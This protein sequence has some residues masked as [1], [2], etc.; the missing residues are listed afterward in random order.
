MEPANDARM[1]R[2]RE[3]I[4]FDTAFRAERADQTISVVWPDM[5]AAPGL[6]GKWT[7]ASDS[8]VWLKG[9]VRRSWMLRHD[10]ETL[11]IRIFVAAGQAETARQHL[12][13]EA[14]NNSLMEIPWQPGPPDLGT[15]ALQSP[16][17][18]S[19]AYLW[20]YRNACFMLKSSFSDLDLLPIARW[21]QAAAAQ[22]APRDGIA[23][24]DA[25]PPATIKAIAGVGQPIVLDLGAA[26]PASA[27]GP[28]LR[29]H[30]PTDSEDLDVLGVQGLSIRV[31]GRR[32]GLARLEVQA[33]DRR[34]L[35]STPVIVE[36][37]VVA[38]GR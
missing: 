15:L 4:G 6:A 26:L 5:L 27:H 16:H 3:R 36:L 33:M 25:A 12:L 38:V 31:A 23:R 14:G 20:V 18:D 30:V 28:Q 37:N 22:G 21:L 32:P 13:E 29:L 7:L 10:R 24:P 11:L 8:M 1:A 2:F 34:S 35:L 19:A 9:G 17:Q